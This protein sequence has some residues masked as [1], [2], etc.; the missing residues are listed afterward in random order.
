MDLHPNIQAYLPVLERHRRYLHRIP[1][2]GKKEFDTQRYLLDILADLDPDRLE[3][4]ADTGIRAVFL[5]REGKQT[6]AFRADMDAL[7]I[8]EGNKHDFVSLNP[9]WMH[10]CGHDGHMAVL[11]TFA[12]LLSIHRGMLRD[13]VVLLFQPAEESVG[14]A[15]RM[16]EAGALKDPDVDRIYALHMAPDLPVGT[17][18]TAIGPLMAG[19][20]EF[21]LEL[22]GEA[23]HGAEPHKGVDAIV[24]AAHLIG[25]LQS[26]LTRTIDPYERTVLTVGRMEAGD[27]RN[28]IAGLARLECTMRAFST[29]TF[30]A[31]ETR[32]RSCLHAVEDAFGV[33]TDFRELV[34]YPPVVN[35]EEETCQVLQLL[36]GGIQTIPPKMVAE[37]FSYFQQAVPGVYMFLG[38]KDDLYAQP[39][40]TPLFDFDE[41]ALVYGLNA[42]AQ[43]TTWNGVPWQ[44]T[45]ADKKG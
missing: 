2:E 7:P 25:L 22:R 1:E 45:T 24:A 5:G 10:A 37:D 20:T 13:H 26:S 11:L 18:G 21:D 33:G 19:T 23:A 40:H 9:G 27:R 8:Q 35:P 12:Q 28:I 3:V 38:C 43:L 30:R 34:H 41:T 32:V 14:G 31:M 42:F 44:R 4:V 29:N 6:V 39:L 15:Q 36:E 17:L 16:I